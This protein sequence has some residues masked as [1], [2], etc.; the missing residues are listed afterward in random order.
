[1]SQQFSL[2]TWPLIPTVLTVCACLSVSSAESST[3][4]PSGAFEAG[5]RE[6]FEAFKKL[7]I[8]PNTLSP[9]R[10]L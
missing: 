7:K 2:Y 3:E 1:M 5:G 10:L 6:W 4:M 8:Q 9:F